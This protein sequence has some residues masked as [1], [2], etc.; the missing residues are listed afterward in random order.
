M[1]ADDMIHGRFS[2]AP[3]RRIDQETPIVP[4]AIAEGVCEEACVWLRQPL[5]RTWAKSLVTHANEAYAHN[6]RFRRRVRNPANAGRDW[7]WAFMRHWLAALIRRNRP[8]LY[9]RLPSTCAVG[10]PLPIGPSIPS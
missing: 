4:R 3:S 7:L 6:A 5:P 9:R 1:I 10:L 8:D 2:P